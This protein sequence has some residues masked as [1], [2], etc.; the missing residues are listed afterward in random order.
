MQIEIDANLKFTEFQSGF[1]DHSHRKINKC[2]C[3]NVLTLMLNDNIYINQ[4][5]TVQN[6]TCSLFGKKR[7]CPV[8]NSSSK[9]CKLKMSSSLVGGNSSDGYL[10][11]G[12][13]SSVAAAGIMSVG[14]R[15]TIQMSPLGDCAFISDFFASA[16]FLFCLD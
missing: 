15:V 10:S 5:Y 12:G 6:I 3:I 13:T 14:R 1:R 8:Q 7:I 11:S 4:L 16:A 2:L 9:A